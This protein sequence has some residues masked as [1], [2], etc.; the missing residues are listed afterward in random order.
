M[1]RNCWLAIASIKEAEVVVESFEGGG[2]HHPSWPD[3]KSKSKR[4]GFNGLASGALGGGGWGRLAHNP[5][6]LHC[7]QFI[8]QLY[9]IIERRAS[10]DTFCHYHPSGYTGYALREREHRS[11]PSLGT[12]FHSAVFTL[13]K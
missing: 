10:S 1:Q 13:I 4:A 6:H 7:Q 12:S 3:S 11:Y 2:I 8:T 5:Q 9:C